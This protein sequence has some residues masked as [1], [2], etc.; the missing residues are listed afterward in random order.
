MSLLMHPKQ[1]EQVAVTS[2]T[3][4]ENDYN[5]HPV[6][7]RKDRDTC[8]NCKWIRSSQ[9]EKTGLKQFIGGNLGHWAR[10][11]KVRKVDYSRGKYDIVTL[12][13][14][15]D[16]SLSSRRPIWLYCQLSNEAFGG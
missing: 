1:A 5:A 4:I 16:S 2:R 12:M 10:E 15:T 11:C 8:Y 13:N 3:V 9:F 14:A 7:S 6:S